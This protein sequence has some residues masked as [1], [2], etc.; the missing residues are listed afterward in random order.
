[1]IRDVELVA[2]AVEVVVGDDEDKRRGRK[3]DGNSRI[4]C[5]YLGPAPFSIP[6]LSLNSDA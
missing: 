6:R 4:F 2:V 3:E 5:R 1:M